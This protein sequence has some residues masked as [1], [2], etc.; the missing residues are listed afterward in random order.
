MKGKEVLLLGLFAILAII[1]LVLMFKFSVTGMM[2]RP[3]LPPEIQQME[4]GA[5]IIG[6]APPELILHE[7]NIPHYKTQEPYYMEGHA[8]KD[9]PQTWLKHEMSE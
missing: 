7:S 9:T 4:R 3:A 6:K 5:G 8:L 2:A 1:G